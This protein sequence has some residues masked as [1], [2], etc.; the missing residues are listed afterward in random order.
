MKYLYVVLFM[1]RNIY[2]N[3]EFDTFHLSRNEK[4]IFF[5]QENGENLKKNNENLVL[6]LF[7]VFLGNSS[8]STSIEEFFIRKIMSK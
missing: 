2:L 3:Y 1:G 5:R 6:F 8:Y 7:F 4:I